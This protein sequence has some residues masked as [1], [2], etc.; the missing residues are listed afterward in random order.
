MQAVGR[1]CDKCG[2]RIGS[3]LEGEGCIRC[4][5]AFH[6]NCLPSPPTDAHTYREPALPP[7]PVPRELA[8]CPVCGLEFKDQQRLFEVAKAVE[9]AEVQQRGSRLEQRFAQVMIGVSVA[10]AGILYLTLRRQPSPLASPEMAPW[11]GAIGLYFV[12]CSMRFRTFFLYQLNVRRAVR[13]YPAPLVHG[14]NLIV[15][16]T[17]LVL[18]FQGWVHRL[19]F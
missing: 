16:L 11:V 9:H 15:G 14:G 2:K 17:A 7:T 1:N 8:T 10:V 19:P 4:D 18:A 5:K 6:F 13:L 3:V 12:V